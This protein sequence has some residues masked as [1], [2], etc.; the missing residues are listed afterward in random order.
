[1][2]VLRHDFDVMSLRETIQPLGFTGT[3]LVQ[4]QQTI[5]ESKWLLECADREP[6]IRGVVGWVPL[7]AEDGVLIPMLE[8]FSQ[9]PRFKGVRH[10]VQDEPDER[11]L[12]RNNFS[13]GIARL[14]GFNL[15]YDLLVYAKQ[16]PSAAALVDRHPEQV[17]VLDHVAKP[18]ISGDALDSSW[19]AN[20][21]ELSR[22]PNVACKFSGLVTE[23]RDQHWSLETLRPYWDTV[24]EAFGIERLM[25]GSDWPVCLLRSRYDQW[26][27]TVQAF[28][29]ELSASDRRMFWHDNA[30]KFYGLDMSDVHP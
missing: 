26:L 27:G 25:F 14:R 8:K 22:R 9:H 11:F 20:L 10:V 16:L 18:T 15:V 28:T 23:V 4:A 13:R 7:A 3:I 6:L 1:M 2:S 19:A 21:K 29:G 17:F 24:V 5:A 12:L 30:V